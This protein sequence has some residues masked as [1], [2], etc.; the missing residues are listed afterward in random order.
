MG[1]SYSTPSVPSSFKVKNGQIEADQL[2]YIISK[3]M[4]NIRDFT[5]EF[6]AAGTPE[7]HNLMCVCRDSRKTLKN[8]FE[9]N[10]DLSK[11]QV[12]VAQD[13]TNALYKIG[14]SRVVKVDFEKAQQRIVSSVCKYKHQFNGRGQDP[15]CVS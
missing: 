2:I 7:C 8:E 1:Q 14:N 13:Y 11:L 4:Y 5:G 9:A 10:V 3:Y 15:K 6:G 12:C